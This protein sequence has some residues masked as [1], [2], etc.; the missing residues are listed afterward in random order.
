MG[1][2]LIMNENAKILVID[3]DEN[4]RKMMELTLKANGYVVDTAGSGKEAVEKSNINF[5]NLA[6][7]DIRLPD[8]E[9]TALLTSLKETT[10]K[11]VKIIV[12]GYPSLNNAVEAVNKDAD[13]YIIKPFK[14]ERLLTLIQQH[15]KKQR[16][17]D[18]YGQKKVSDYIETRIKQNPL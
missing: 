6:L 10:P 4:V 18:E 8:M 17:E 11:L 14:T 1:G 12:T 2:G 3:D 15:L 13:G 5:Y 7:I 16:D 9:G